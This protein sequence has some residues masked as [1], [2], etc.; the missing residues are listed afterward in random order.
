M[1]SHS[2][3]GYHGA[4]PRALSLL[5]RVGRNGG[6]Y[7][8][9]NHGSSSSHGYG[10]RRRTGN[11]VHVKSSVGG[12]G[13]RHRARPKSAGG[14][15]NSRGRFSSGLTVAK[16][17]DGYG[18]GAK[19]KVKT[20]ALMDQRGHH[21][22]RSGA[23]AG[24]R[25]S[26]G[27]GIGPF[28]ADDLHGASGH[29][30][31]H[32]RPSTAQGY[33]SSSSRGASARGVAD[34][35]AGADASML[36]FNI[37]GRRAIHAREGTGGGGGASTQPQPPYFLA[38]AGK[39]VL[40]SSGGG[41]GGAPGGGGGG[42]GFASSHR[43][44]FASSVPSNP[45]RQQYQQAMQRHQQQQQQQQQRQRQRQQDA[46]SSHSAS[47]SS[48]SS[49]PNTSRRNNNAPASAEAA[50]AG[51]RD[52][53]TAATNRAGSPA[54]LAVGCVFT[55]SPNYP[56]VPI[57]YRTA[58]QRAENS[59]RLNLDRINLETMPLL[60]GEHRLRLLNYQNNMLRKICHLQGLPNLIFL[61]LYNNRI[62]RIEGL[63]CVPALRV[64][65][66]GKNA[67]R[68]VENLEPLRKLDVLDLHSNRIAKIQRLSHLV[69]LR[70]LNLA[71]NAVDVVDNLAGLRSLTELN[72]RRNQI[73]RVLDL[74]ALPALQRV[75]LSH[76]EIDSF[77]DVGCVFRS[78]SLCELALSHNPVSLRG[79]GGETS[80]GESGGVSA[81][82]AGGAGN[83]ASET[84]NSAENGGDGDQTECG[85][86][87]EIEAAAKDQS[88]RKRAAASEALQEYRYH[89]ISSLPN[90]THLD[91]QRISDG[92]RKT[93]KVMASRKEDRMQ[94]EIR[95]KRA[96]GQRDLAI[97]RARAT[98]KARMQEREKAQ[99]L[100]A[101]RVDSGGGRERD[102]GDTD[103]DG[104]KAGGGWYSEVEMHGGAQRLCL[105]GANTDPLENAKLHR[106]V[107]EI[108]MCYV[109]FDC[110]VC[111]NFSKLHHFERLRKVMLTHN[112]LD[113]FQ[114]LDALRRLVSRRV[115]SG[116]RGCCGGSL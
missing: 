6:S 77:D 5:G 12:G 86:G 2:T 68:N 108:S 87:A 101:G 25:S 91:L 72:L 98:W 113:S 3:R 59:E 61:D 79:G 41:G 85:D 65:M 46:P 7:G 27:N 106:T 97:S 88:D 75:F 90:L 55:Q 104:G 109:D 49:D 58:A 38:P 81:E 29:H 105:Y 13:A 15:W 22:P 14:Q 54:D 92:D 103:G 76:N 51:Q 70:V 99:M 110:D 16:R 33:P 8:M 40:P 94:H 93:A 9:A 24:R 64:L 10:G 36:Q 62:E 102:S 63:A 78:K 20:S 17:T 50:A 69:E 39:G 21:H 11:V 42:G 95:Q 114:S 43:R 28:V 74:D 80:R 60:E 4:D 84:A 57:V 31:H 35:G 116:S 96:R 44:G 34:A 66:L 18:I 48:S 53:A 73:E 82:G 23:G 32:Q 52:G 37:T 107:E 112:G 56:G 100:A 45:T 30:Q 89:V 111:K 26:A 19:A 47:S 71:G 83:K 1:R 115:V 67:I